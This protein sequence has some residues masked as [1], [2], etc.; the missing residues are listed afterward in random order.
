MTVRFDATTEALS[1]SANLPPVN[2]WT[3]LIR[4]KRSAARGAESTLIS[5]ESSGGANGEYLYLTSSNVLAIFGSSSGA[6]TFASTP[7]VGVEFDCALIKNSG[8]LT[9]YWKQVGSSTWITASGASVTAYTPAV[10]RLGNDESNSWHNG[11]ICHAKLWDR[12]LTDNELL[13][14]SFFRRVM[15]PTSL[16]GH[17]PLE[18][19]TD[20]TDRSGNGRSLTATGTLATEESA[21]Q[22]WKAGARVMRRVASG[23]GGAGGRLLSSKLSRGGLLLGGS[24]IR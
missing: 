18:T 17:W 12:V 4:A 15:Y 14:E 7:S 20:L 6:V 11:T 19:H 10:F 9:G 23:G 21:W 5:L 13:A 3:C 1:R 16:N 2:S 22:P 8:T 24:L